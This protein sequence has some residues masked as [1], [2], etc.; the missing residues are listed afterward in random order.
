MRMKLITMFLLAAMAYLLAVLPVLA[1]DD[2]KGG[3]QNQPEGAAVTIPKV[4]GTFTLY[5]SQKPDHASKLE[6]WLASG[7]VLKAGWQGKI[8]KDEHLAF[9]GKPNRRG[10]RTS[11]RDADLEKLKGLTALQSLNFYRCNKITDAGL[12]HLKGLT[13]LQSLNL[14]LCNEITDAGLAHLKDLTALKRLDLSGC[15]KVT[16]DGV[17]AL[18]KSLPELVVKR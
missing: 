16:D 18:K 10:V 7:K 4:T 13:A 2:A 9:A 11:T 3:G 14:F 17:A 8:G 15:D 12:E 6:E 5:P 1:Q